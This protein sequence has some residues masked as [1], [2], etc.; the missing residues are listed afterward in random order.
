ML[1]KIPG[2]TEERLGFL[3]DYGAK[4]LKNAE[5]DGLRPIEFTALLVMLVETSVQTHMEFEKEED[6]N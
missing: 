4:I 5:Q 3:M 1:A 2:M 6:T